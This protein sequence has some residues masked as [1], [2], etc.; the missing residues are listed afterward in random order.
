VIAFGV[1]LAPV[2]ILTESP[3][4]QR[5]TDGSPIA[6]VSPLLD[7]DVLTE[8]GVPA[9]AIDGDGALLFEPGRLAGLGVAAGDV[10]GLRV[11][12]GGFELSD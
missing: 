11:T 3:T 7:G 12:S 10:V 9:S 1:D 5:L 2:S 6:D 8:R 4:F